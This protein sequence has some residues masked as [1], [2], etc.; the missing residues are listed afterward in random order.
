MAAKIYELHGWKDICEQVAT[1]K[2]TLLNDPV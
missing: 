1:L 2:D